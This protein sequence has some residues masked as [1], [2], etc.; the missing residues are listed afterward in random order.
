MSIIKIDI[1]N[2][3]DLFIIS[4]NTSEILNK[5]RIILSFKRLG[6]STD[7]DN[8]IIPF[9]EE[10]QIKTLQE[11]QRLLSKFD[12]E[13][14]LAENTKNELESFYREE[15]LF[16]VFSEKAMSIRNDEF[17][18]KPELVILFEQFQDI[19]KEKLERRLYPLQLLSA[20]H[21]AFAQNSCN[22]AVPG[23][24][25]TSIVYGAYA[26]LKS[27]PKEHPSHVDKLLVIGPIS[28]FAP[29][30]KEYKKCFGYS[31]K[32]FRMSGD[33]EISREQKEQHLY[34]ATSSELTLIFHGGVDSYENDIIDFLKRNKTMVV[35]D[36]AHRIKNPEGVWGRSVTEISKEAISR[37]ILTGTPVPNGYQD[38]FNLYKF[39]YPFRFKEILKFH[40]H[41]LEDMTYNSQPES[42]RVQEL[43][44]NI[45]PYFI[46][47]KKEDL[48]LPGIEEH[49]MSIEM[50]P[51]QREIYDFIESQYI[52]NFKENDSATVKDILNKAKLIRL[53]QASTNPSL[54]SK[55]LKDSLE[56]GVLTDEVD[57]NSIFTTHTDEF[58]ND[59]EFFNKICKYSEIETPNKFVQILNLI[60]NEI[61]PNNGKVI[62][63][64]IFIQ[65]AK[66]LQNYLR[67]NSIKSNLLIGEISQ[68]DREI[69][70]DKFNNPNNSEFQVVIANPFSV[71]E[72]I[73]LHKG[74]HNAIYLERDYNC[75]NF[76]QSK[77]R[78]HRVGLDQ[79]QI[80]KYYYFISKDSIDEVINHRL[81]LKI[82][83]ME[84][85]INDD[86]P[87]FSRINDNDETDIIKE[88]IANYAQRT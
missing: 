25:K 43:K 87:L 34:S 61:L 57:P 38:I 80:T 81:L 24:G 79:N 42:S 36:E 21:M 78:I 65:N 30:E 18:D 60:E 59:S 13:H 53:R 72:S 4:G 33:S 71:A 37:V 63:W 74:C 77:D 7:N 26:Y 29:W 22:F 35:V 88:L 15:K 45:S 52:E 55:T 19:L 85:I 66:E 5:K 44:E 46:R 41:N 28:S 47:I 83:R 76:L 58:V 32:S 1:N 17:N 10:T 50:N 27:L 56:N 8:I 51:Y 31:I 84:E 75:S 20:F 48:N 70:I 54:L 68:P 23:A 62:I 14:E 69:T 6:Y 3:S 39:I 12:F 82:A 67:L 11:I 86:I 2:D 73:S 9:R 64:T 49:L 40:Y 16:N